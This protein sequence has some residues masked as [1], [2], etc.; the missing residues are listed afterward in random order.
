M[1]SFYKGNLRNDSLRGVNHGWIIGSF[2]DDGPRRTDNVEI[3]YWEYPIGPTSHE[4][5][6]SATIEATFILKGKTLAEIDGNRLVLEA[7]DY[8][9][10]SPNIPNNTV[11]DILAEAA[12][13]T[14]KA[15]SD[16]SAKR[17]IP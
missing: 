10:I 3:K 12:G 13:L 8:V 2:M 15:P 1:K 7:G 5:K 14:V 4:R 9:V 17:V 6:V 16:T 11:L